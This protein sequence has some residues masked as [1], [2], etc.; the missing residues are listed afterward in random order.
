MKKRL[1]Y[2]IACAGIITTLLFVTN[3]YAATSNISLTIDGKQTVGDVKTIDGKTYIALDALNSVD[4]LTI[5]KTSQNVSIATNNISNIVSKVSPSV[6]GIIGKL[7]ESSSNYNEMT[8]N[9]VFGTGVI[10]RSDGYIVTNAHVVKEMESIVVVLSNSKPYKAR[11]KAI[12]EKLDLATIKIDKGG[13]TPA[14]FGD[15]NKVTVGQEVVAIGTPLSFSLRNSATRGIVSGM[16]R[17]AGG[18]YRFIQSDTA[19]NGGNSG[20]PLVNMQGQVIGINSV[21][22][23]GYGVEGLSFSIPIDTVQYAIKHFE[24]FG[25]IKRP[26]L[27]LNFSE[28]IAA[29]YGLPT[30]EEGINIQ[31]IDEGSPAEDYDLSVEDKLLSVNG[32]KVNTIIDYNEEMKKYYPGD[33]ATLLLVRDGKKISVNVRFAQKD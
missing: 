13:L 10:Y 12:D 7:K 11:L 26:Y 27:G 23:M 24:K 16:N 17:V 22:F 3:V 29:Q 9:L 6:V 30:Y 20:G 14:T 21:K 4:G 8:D 2:K 1:G 32:V 19:I 31:D 25:K 18:E 15:I 33:S 28:S 5:S